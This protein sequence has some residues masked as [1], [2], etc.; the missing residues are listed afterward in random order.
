MGLFAAIHAV[1]V[2]E[3]EHAAHEHVVPH[4]CVT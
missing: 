3:D 4:V 1:V 2:G